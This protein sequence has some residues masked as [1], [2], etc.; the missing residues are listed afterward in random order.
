M[1]KK[2]DKR[3]EKIFN[4]IFG[5]KQPRALKIMNEVTCLNS[6][7]HYFMSNLY[8]KLIDGKYCINDAVYYKNNLDFV[9]ELILNA[10]HDLGEIIQA[11]D[12]LVK[13]MDKEDKKLSKEF[14]AKT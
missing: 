3:A 6:Q 5:L 7:F 8:K 11:H 2:V 9:A 4:D 10:S 12:D 13:K 14:K 1:T